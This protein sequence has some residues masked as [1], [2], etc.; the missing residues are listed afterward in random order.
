MLVVYTSVPK[1]TEQR[2]SKSASGARHRREPF[3]VSHSLNKF[4][5]TDLEKTLKDHGIP[6]VL[7]IGTFANGAVLTTASASAELGFKVIVPVD[8]ISSR[9]FMPSNS[10][11]GI[12][13]T[14][15]HRVQDFAHDIRDDEI[16][17]TFEATGESQ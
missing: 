3:V 5:N 14:A 13:P 7:V 2:P 8:G 17:G 16:L 6:T 12:S 1:A 4:L 10:R 9:R 11:P 15:H